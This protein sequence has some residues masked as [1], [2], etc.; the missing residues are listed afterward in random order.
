[1][2]RACECSLSYVGG[3]V[4]V[5][6]GRREDGEMAVFRWNGRTDGHWESGWGGWMGLTRRS[7]D[8]INKHCLREFRRHWSCLDTNNQ[9]LWQCRPAE[10]VLNKC[11]FENLVRP[12]A[13]S[14]NLS[15][16]ACAGE[17]HAA[18]W[19]SWDEWLIR[20]RNWRRSS[21]VRRRGRCR[22]ICGN[23]RFTRRTEGE[24]GMGEV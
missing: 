3:Y 10:R 23:D 11:V 24:D 4:G 21:R 22:C 9:Q 6:V 17:R 13:H 16:S 14:G 8:D 5:G 12:L 19:I 18:L 15:T 7:I 20:E 1:M 2:R